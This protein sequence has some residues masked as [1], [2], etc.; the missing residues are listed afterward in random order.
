MPPAQASAPPPSDSQDE[1]DS[2]EKRSQEIEERSS[3]SG[4]VVYGAIAKEGEAELRRSN[5]ALAWSGL[6]A[7]LSMGFSMVS[8]A[9][10]T[11]SL[12]DTGWRPLVARLGYGVGFLIVVLGRQQ[13]F[14]ENTLTVM[15]PLLQRRDVRTLANVLRL[16][17]VVLGAN[18]GGAFAFAW[19]AGHTSVFEPDLRAEFATLGRHA[20]EPAFGTVLLRGIFAGWLIALMVWLLPFA[21][22]SRLWVGLIITYLV[23]LGKFSHVIAGSVETLYLVTTGARSFGAYAGGFLLPTLLCNIIGVVSLV[24]LLGHAQFIATSQQEDQN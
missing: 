13:L 21:E 10:L 4:H 9:L 20:L 3:P 7:G 18:L 1:Q 22:S 14:T 12:P 11:H 2:D 19:V 17:G 24:S 23:A 6:A 16:W 15:L 5:S 8:E